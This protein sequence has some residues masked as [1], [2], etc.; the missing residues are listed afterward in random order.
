MSKIQIR[1]GTSGDWASSNP[2]LAPAEMGLETD[3]KKLKIGDGTTAWN[4]LRYVAFDG[5][6]L[7]NQLG[8]TMPPGGGGG[9]GGCS[10]ANWPPLMLASIGGDTITGL[11]SG[12]VRVADCQDPQNCTFQE[13][14]HVYGNP[15]SFFNGFGPGSNNTP[16]TIGETI[17]ITNSAL[18][19]TYTIT[20]SQPYAGTT[21]WLVDC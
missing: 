1:K 10:W 3:T 21:Q 5:G 4:N 15:P 14:L 18:A 20:G 9:N 17:V 6:N 7:D 2:T 12:A 16:F 8:T 19:G 13:N 11:T